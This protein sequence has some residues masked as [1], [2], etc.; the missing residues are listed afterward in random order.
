MAAAVA[1]AAAA[2]H[3][4]PASSRGS[5]RGGGSGSSGSRLMAVSCWSGMAPS[6]SGRCSCQRC[7]S[8]SGG[9]H[10]TPA[11]VSTDV[12]LHCR[13]VEA[14]YRCLLHRVFAQLASVK[15][16]LACGHVCPHVSLRQRTVNCRD[17]LVW[18]KAGM[19][20]HPGVCSCAHVS[21]ATGQ[22]IML[23][24]CLPALLSCLTAALCCCER[25]GP[26]WGLQSLP[27]A[28]PLIAAG[29]TCRRR[30]AGGRAKS[31][32]GA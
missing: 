22:P 10:T 3:Q 4:G 20:R 28:S 25:I 27:V 32:M 23:R 14:L 9:S 8:A 24:R 12:P 18:Q 19:P 13:S 26:S 15:L 11:P 2:R 1:A 17:L 6:I 7:T 30:Q 29:R 21:T 16:Q 31:G 5:S